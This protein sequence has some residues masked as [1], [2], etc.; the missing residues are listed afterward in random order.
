MTVLPK[1][2]QI[3]T[4]ASIEKSKCSLSTLCQSLPVPQNEFTYDSTNFISMEKREKAF[5]DARNFEI[6]RVASRTFTSI[7]ECSFEPLGTSDK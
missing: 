3:E 4:T 2:D 6:P 7:R 5:S 1:S